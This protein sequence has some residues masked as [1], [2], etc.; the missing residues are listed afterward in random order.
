MVPQLA[1]EQPL[2][3]TLQVT[4][5]F[6]AFVTVAVNCCVFPAITCADVGEMDTATGGRIVTAADADF[7]ESATEVAVTATRA[8]LGTVAGAV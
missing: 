5:V 8:G 2:P 6:V 1:P 4:A 3:A 7:V